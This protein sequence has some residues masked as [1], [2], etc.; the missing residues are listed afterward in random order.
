MESQEQSAADPGAK[1][2]SQ[3]NGQC[4]PAPRLLEQVR[5]VMRLGHYSI[6]TERSYVDWIKRYIHFH[7]MRTRE[8]LANGEGKIEA[9]CTDL[10]VKGKVAPSTQNQ[11]FNA[12]IF[13]YRQVLK[14]P[15]DEKTTDTLMACCS[16]HPW[17]CCDSSRSPH[18]GQ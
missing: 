4:Q 11:A 2:G 8:D 16:S 14:L 18:I 1:G 17:S 6:H 9:F 3:A 15:L 7:H 12:L 10:A 5:N 13:L